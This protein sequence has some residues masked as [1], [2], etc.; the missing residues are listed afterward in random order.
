MPVVQLRSDALSRVRR[1]LKTRSD[2]ELAKR[3]GVSRQTLRLTERGDRCPSSVFMA[4][5]V[6]ATNK[7][8][9]TWFKVA[10]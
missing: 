2:E 10:Q 3:L 4:G 5:V 7:D 1:V 8:F 9:S 6:A